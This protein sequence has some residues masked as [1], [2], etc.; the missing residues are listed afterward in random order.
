VENAARNF[1]VAVQNSLL[2]SLVFQLVIGLAPVLI[3][4]G[5]LSPSRSISGYALGLMI[6]G[7]ALIFSA[8]LTGHVANRRVRVSSGD[9]AASWPRNGF[10]AW[11]EVSE[12]GLRPSP[13]MRRLVTRLGSGKVSAILFCIPL[14]FFLAGCLAVIFPEWFQ[15]RFPILA[16]DD[17][18]RRALEIWMF[19]A[20]AMSI[21]QWALYSFKRLAPSPA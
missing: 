15:G 20:I 18:R 21:R 2:G 3:L 10:D 4:V 8:W 11:R 17:F 19:A 14:L 5:T 6:L 1:I 12:E 13:F 9:T 7:V 16:V